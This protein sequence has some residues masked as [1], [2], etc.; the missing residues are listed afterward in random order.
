[1]RW[2][3]HRCLLALLLAQALTSVAAH[4]GGSRSV[5]GGALR[6]GDDA[7]HRHIQRPQLFP[8]NVA[9]IRQLPSG[10]RFRVRLPYH[11]LPPRNS[12][13]NGACPAGVRTTLLCVRLTND[14][15]GDPF[16]EA[17]LEPPSKK[18]ILL[19]DKLGIP[20][21]KDVPPIIIINPN[22]G[23][24]QLNVFGFP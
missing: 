17:L 2:V 14:R 5:T 9:Y 24:R 6:R 1:M 19:L 20:A 15:E 21:I 7:T 16:V 8:K 18:T 12:S 10:L 22:R 11:T 3:N 13:E 4:D 23:A